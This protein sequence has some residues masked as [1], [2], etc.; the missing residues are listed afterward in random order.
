MAYP[1]HS[2]EIERQIID[3]I[4]HDALKAGLT[5]SVYDGEEWP[6]KRS[7]DYEAIT[8]EVHA[9][10]E[11]LFLFRIAETGA[12]FGSVYLVHGNDCDVISDYSDN[13]QT[14]AI[15]ANALALAERFANA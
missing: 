2:R 5:I 14:E 10:C 13:P 15:L 3:L 11:T 12:K 8:A 4:I 6:L 9:T 7:T 1:E